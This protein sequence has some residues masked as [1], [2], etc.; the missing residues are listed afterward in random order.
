MKKALSIVLALALALSLAVC[1]FAKEPL[2]ERPSKSPPTYQDMQAKM[3]RAA[4]ARPSLTYE[5]PTVTDIDAVWNGEVLFNYYWFELY[6]SPANVDVTVT[7][8]D[9]S[10]E[11]LASWWGEGYSAISYWWWEIYYEYDAAA[12]KVTFYYSDSNLGR[13]YIDSL[14]NPEEDFRW[15]DYLTTLPQASFAVPIGL[16]EDILNNLAAVALQLDVS[17]A[18]ILAEGERKL[19]S[20]TPEEDGYYRF[21]SLDRD[22]GD[23]YGILFDADLQYITENDD[24][25]GDLNFSMNVWLQADNT[26]YLVAGSYSGA[27]A[28]YKVMVTKSDGPVSNDPVFALNTDQYVISYGTYDYIHPWQ[29]I[30]EIEDYEN[31]YV[32]GQP[33]WWYDYDIY[34]AGTAPGTVMTLTY[35]TADG[36][37]VLGTVDVVCKMSAL[38]RFCYYVLGGWFWM[39]R[40]PLVYFSPYMTFGNTLFQILLNKLRLPLTIWFGWY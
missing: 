40:L 5:L 22:S 13:A 39:P 33:L 7:F 6:F 2:P 17:Q 34:V 23:P 35:T 21:Y 28:S 29:F 11:V 31:V 32:N 3:S 19:F 37:T 27:P 18:A 14:A 38:Q 25:G 10:S 30:E 16:L 1:A 9:G 4:A 8:D 15:E 12:G 26:Y 24:G 36:A 20:F